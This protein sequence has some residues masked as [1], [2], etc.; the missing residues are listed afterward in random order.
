MFLTVYS[1]SNSCYYSYQRFLH[2]KEANESFCIA[3]AHQPYLR[4]PLNKRDFA[5]WLNCDSSYCTCNLES[6]ASPGISLQNLVFLIDHVNL[7]FTASI[8]SDTTPNSKSLNLLL[9]N[10]TAENFRCVAIIRQQFSITSD[11]SET[12]SI[13]F[14]Q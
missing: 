6:S 13:I 3:L 1:I 4:V 10:K 11:V 14:P 5:C 7:T 2:I 9:K 8:T 12:H